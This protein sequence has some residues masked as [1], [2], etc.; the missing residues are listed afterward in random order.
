MCRMG[1]IEFMRVSDFACSHK[2]DIKVSVDDS[3]I[4]LTLCNTPE[5]RKRDYIV[6]IM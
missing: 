4:E 6:N 5:R 1:S 3:N 2:A